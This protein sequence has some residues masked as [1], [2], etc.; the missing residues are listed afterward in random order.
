MQQITLK[1]TGDLPVQF[2]GEQIA[3]S[4]RRPEHPEREKFIRYHEVALYRT[5]S[6]RY[7]ISIN[8]ISTSKGEDNHSLVVTCDDREQV[9][10]QLLEE[11]DPVD[12]AHFTGYPKGVLDYD[13]KQANLIAALERE[14]DAQ[15]SEI[16]SQARFVETID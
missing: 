9:A 14:W 11:Y 1:R 7:V 16:L 13:D 4:T 10:N 3:S 12:P 2:A 5:Q 15:V 8:Y 6:G